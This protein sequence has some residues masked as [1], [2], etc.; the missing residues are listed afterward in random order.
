MPIIDGKCSADAVLKT[1]LAG[2]DLT[3]YLM[4]MLNEK[5]YRFTT[6]SER[7]I[8]RNVKE[9]FCHFAL[10][11]NDEMQAPSTLLEKTYR[12]PGGKVITIGNKKL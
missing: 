5:P 8:V 6:S 1:H 9:K 4:R 3:D 10:K 12:L 11:Y 7:D 2:G